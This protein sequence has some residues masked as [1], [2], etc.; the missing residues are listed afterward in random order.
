MSEQEATA[1][2]AEIRLLSGKEFRSLFPQSRMYEERF[3]G[4]T[5]SY[6]AY[7]L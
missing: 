1:I 3:L 5:K 2:M 6:T 7:T 4:M